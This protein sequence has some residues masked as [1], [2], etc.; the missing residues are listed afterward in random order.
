MMLQ[1]IECFTVSAV[2]WKKSRGWGRRGKWDTGVGAAWKNF[3][4]IK[5]G[6]FHS[7]H[8]FSHGEKPHCW[9]PGIAMHVFVLEGHSILHLIHADLWHFLTNEALFKQRDSLIGTVNL[10]LDI[11]QERQAMAEL[12][13]EILSAMQQSR[14]GHTPCTHA[15]SDL[16]RPPLLSVVPQIW[17]PGVQLLSD[18]ATRLHYRPQL[19]L[20]NGTYSYSFFISQSTF[21]IINSFD[22]TTS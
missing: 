12:A 18:L 9:S 6:L 4:S 15:L 16:P 21:T 2:E 7:G 14:G 1:H 3:S 17:Q 8:L 11:L 13:Q 22:T 5:T 10:E 20:N 19:T